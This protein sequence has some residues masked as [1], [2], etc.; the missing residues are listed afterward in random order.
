MG[1]CNFQIG[2]LSKPVND[3]R[4]ISQLLTDLGFE[5]ILT[6]KGIKRL[7]EKR[8]HRLSLAI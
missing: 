2:H 5:V 3:A 6:T 4:E 8:E 1:N 7:A